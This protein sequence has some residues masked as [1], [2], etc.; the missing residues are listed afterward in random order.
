[1][2]EGTIK[3]DSEISL[4]EKHA[5]EISVSFATQILFHQKQDKTA[6]EKILTVDALS[7]E[8]KNRFLK[9]L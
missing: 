2:E 8:W 4:L 5:K 1:L 9:L 3:F 6:I 7:E